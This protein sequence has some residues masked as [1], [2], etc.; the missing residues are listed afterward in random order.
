[1]C[2]ADVC[3]APSCEDGEKNGGEV[4][5][6]CGAVCPKGCAPGEPCGTA[7]DCDSKICSGP[8]G[9]LVCA[10]PSCFDGVPNGGEPAWDCGGPC[11]QK[12]PPLFPCFV[13][14]DCMG[15]L[16]DPMTFTCS[17]T[18]TDGYENHGETDRDCGGPCPEKCAKGHHCL[19]NTDCDGGL[20]CFLGHCCPD[21][22][23]CCADGHCPK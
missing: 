13:D 7:A 19:V 23:V 17:P 21:G 18:C 11:A 5:V 1:M 16:C 3:T 9:G 15:S 6:D 4:G 12:C 8:P 10:V 14:T 20:A 22:T 2:K